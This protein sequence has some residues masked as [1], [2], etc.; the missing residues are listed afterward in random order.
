MRRFPMLLVVVLSGLG[1]QIAI[2]ADPPARATESA[3]TVDLFY[4][5]NRRY[6]TD[7]QQRPVLSPSLGHPHCGRA[8]ASVPPGHQKGVW[9]RPSFGERADTSRH[10]AVVS[11]RPSTESEFFEQLRKRL[12][13]QGG[14]E[15]L[16]FVHGT[17]SPFEGAATRAAQLAVDLDH[18]GP[19]IFFSWPSDAGILPDNYAADT[20]RLSASIPAF[21]AFLQTLSNQ[22]PEA[23]INVLAHSLGC[24]LVA[25][26]LTSLSATSTRLDRPLLNE[27]IF[28]AADMDAAAFE[29]VHLGP[30]CSLLN[31]LTLYVSSQDRLLAVSRNAHWGRFRLGQKR[32]TMICHPRV[33]TV[34]VSLADSTAGFFS[35]RHRY[36]ADSPSVLQDEAALLRGAANEAR[37]MVVEEQSEQSPQKHFIIEDE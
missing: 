14:H 6:E 10:F 16:L 26:S 2:C 25:C 17:N 37:R 5:S 18:E 19:V 24:Q 7:S 13:E 30:I 8:V 27:V 22:L 11:V 23:N 1:P 34:D 28:A 9:E 33:E 35:T 31:R 15:L 29:T 36:Y 12:L 4:C 20:E 21:E 3:A 32:P